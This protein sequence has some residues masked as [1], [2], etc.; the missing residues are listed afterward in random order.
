MAVKITIKLEDFSNLSPGGLLG[1]AKGQV[2]FSPA[3]V[4]AAANSTIQVDEVDVCVRAYDSY[5]FP[6]LS[7][8]FLFFT[9]P[10]NPGPTTPVSVLGGGG[11]L[12]APPSRLA[13][14]WFEFNWLNEDT[15]GSVVDSGA[16]ATL[17]EPLDSTLISLLNNAHWKLFDGVSPSFIT[18]SNLAPIPPGP[19][20]VIPLQ[21]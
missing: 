2:F 8:P 12:W 20:V 21:P 4:S 19:T 3:L 15:I 10:L 16:T 7:D 17:E 9:F 13:E 18:A 5:T 6:V 1:D 14:A 11:V